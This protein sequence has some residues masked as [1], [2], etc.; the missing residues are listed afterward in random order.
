MNNSNEFEQLQDTKSILS[1]SSNFDGDASKNS[2]N[3]MVTKLL[4]I[5]PNIIV[6]DNNDD[7]NEN[8]DR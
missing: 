2:S 6:E 7:L 8:V 3:T 5:S 4:T 1:T